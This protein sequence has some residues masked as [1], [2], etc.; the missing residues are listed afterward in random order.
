MPCRGRLY[1]FTLLVT[2]LLVSSCAPVPTAPTRSAGVLSAEQLKKLIDAKS[3][4]FLVDTRTEY[5]FKKGRVPGA[6]NIPPHRFD[7]L[8]SLLPPDKGLHLVFYCRGSG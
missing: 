5:E 8:A 2:A 3:A 6:V 1:V 7:S 4:L